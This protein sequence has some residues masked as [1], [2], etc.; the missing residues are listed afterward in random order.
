MQHANMQHSQHCL[1]IQLPWQLPALPA[2]GLLVVLL[3][4][5]HL[6]PRHPSKIV[7]K[8]VRRPWE[9]YSHKSVIDVKCYSVIW[10][11]PFWN[12]ILLK[13]LTYIWAESFAIKHS[14]L[15]TPSTTKFGIFCLL[16]HKK[17][18]EWSQIK[19]NPATPIWLTLVALRF[20]INT[21][22][23]LAKWL[24]NN[25]MKHLRLRSVSRFCRLGCCRLSHRWL[26]RNLLWFFGI[27]GIH[28]FITLAKLLQ[29][30]MHP[31]L[32]VPDAPRGT[33][34]WYTVSFSKTA[35]LWIYRPDIVRL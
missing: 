13:E 5:H 9:R 19:W 14:A 23:N 1:Q 33:G 3:P 4:L 20:I 22:M 26:R 28:V 25:N 2:L 18:P 6:I 7:V 34:L 10:S 16:I 32:S 31:K 30:P 27:I 17:I 11:C 29:N 24:L 35:T 21:Q 12:T 15:V 8:S